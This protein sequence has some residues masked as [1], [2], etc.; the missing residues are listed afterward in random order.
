MKKTIIFFLFLCLFGVSP[1]FAGDIVTVGGYKFP[2]FVQKEGRNVSGI[3]IDIIDAMNKFQ[4]EYT[5]NFVF[6]SPKRRYLAF[7]NNKF[8]M[9]MFESKSWGWRKYPVK[10]S[11]V[12]LRGGEVYIAL[13]EP[14]RGESFFSNFKNKTMIGILGYHYGFAGYNSDSKYL[15]KNFNMQLTTSNK[16]S[17][18]MVLGGRGDIA[19]VTRSFLSRYLSQNPG[20]RK[21]LLISKKMDQVY[22][23]RILIRKGSKP[24]AGEMNKILKAMKKAGVLREIWKKYGIKKPGI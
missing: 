15:R 8:N 16:G 17:I 19:V 23:H 4:K 20:V 21:K 2:P 11:K 5:F 22:N 18:L 6:T 24:G 1:V 14:G 13:A 7:N 9:I 3:T 10:M 12:F